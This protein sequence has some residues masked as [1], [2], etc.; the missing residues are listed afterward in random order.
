[1]SERTVTCVILPHDLQE[2]PEVVQPPR[3]HGSTFS[4]VGSTTPRVVP[5]DADLAAAAAIL[6]AG[7]RV[8]ILIGQGAMDAAAEVLDVAD[9][10][11]G[12]MGQAL[13]GQAGAGAE[14]PGGT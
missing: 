11:G 9:R 14:S 7:E 12:G 13:L 6:N 10:L 1:I 5:R 3:E 8:A 2:L 4:G